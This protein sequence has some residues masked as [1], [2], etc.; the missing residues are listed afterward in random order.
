MKNLILKHVIRMSKL[1]TYAFL[2]QCLTMGLLLASN[3]NAQIKSI[4]EV[5]VRLPMEGVSVKDAFK[6]IEEASDFTFVYLT[7]EVRNLPPIFVEGRDQSLYEVLVEIA[8]QSGLDFKQINQNIH[9]Q[10]SRK[11]QEESIVS[12]SKV[13]VEIRGT[14]TE[15]NGD[16]IPGATILVEGSNT[17]TATDIDG[18]FSL[19]VDEGS[20]LLISFIG[21]KSQR[22]TVGNQ[23]SL[24]ITLMEDQSSLEEVVVVGYGAVRKRDLTG[25]I[26]SVDIEQQNEMPNVSV[27]QSL[28][29]RIP[30]L[31]VGAI[32]QSGQDPRIEVRGQNTLS[33]SAGDN[34]PLIVLDGII[35]RGNIIDINPA[36]IQS[37]EVLKDGSAAAIYGSQAAN[38]VIL[39]TSK[40]GVEM[41]K[42]IINYS[43]QYTIQ[44]PTKNIRPRN[45]AENKAFLPNVFWEQ[46]RLAPDYLQPNPDFIVTPFLKTQ[47][48]SE[49]YQTD[50]D[51]DWWGSFTGNGNIQTHDLSIRGRTANSGYFIAAGITDQKG[52]IKNDEYNRI[53]IT[54]NFDTQIT[55]WLN[56]GM[57]TFMTSSDYSGV[58]PGVGTVFH[59]QPFAPIFDS[60][61]NYELQPEAGLNPFLQTQIDDEDKR[62]NLFGNFHL[63]LKLPFLPGFN[64]RVNYGH[65]YRN[66][67]HNQF[68]PWGANFTGSGFKNTGN[69]YSYILDNI[70]SYE[71]S[72]AEDH[73]LSLTFLYGVE[74]I[75]T[76]FT[77]ASAQ[78]FSNP[79]LG[80]FR[81]QAGDPSL[82]AIT[83]GAEEESSLYNMGRILYGYKDRYLITATIRRD[84]F[85]GFGANNKFGI[86]PSI[87]A[88]WVVSEEAFFDKSLIEFLKIRASYG[89]TARRGVGRY[90]T[91]ARMNAAPSRVFGDGGSATIGQWITTMANPNLAWET[92]T[93]LNLGVDF[94]MMNSRLFGNIE[95][96]NNNTEDILYNIQIPQTTGFSNIA[97][98]IGE[99]FNQ[100]IEFSLTGEPIRTGDFSWQATLNFSRNRN[101]IRSILGADND[102][103]GIEDDIVTNQLFI[104]EPQNVVFDYEV[105][106]MWQ[107]ED[108]VPQGFFPGTYRLN[109]VDED[110]IIS[111]GDRKILG[112]RDPS[113]RLGFANTL[114]YKNLSLY[115][116]INSIQGGQD[117]YYADGSP[118]ASGALFKRDQLTYSNAMPFDYWMP[119]NPNAKYRRLDLPSSF[120]GRPY[121]QRSF[122]RLQ[123]ISLAYSFEPGILEK[124]KISSLKVN[125]SAKNL[126]TL[127]NWEGWDP[128]TGIGMVAGLPVMKAYTLGLNVQF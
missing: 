15:E 92:T 52:F 9:V 56:F 95:Y 50:R 57:E 4:E 126:V 66:N 110:G 11:G 78:N 32:T 101:E 68:N 122:V 114:R 100:G 39:L 124:W 7:R 98:N 1:F 55:D 96:Y 112:Y 107:L 62:L 86:F 75:Q 67:T 84:G 51:N 12:V 128:E 87:A 34:A 99:V 69:Y 115:V 19:D 91:Q 104:G 79:T 37:V 20:V 119:E 59:L 82:N 18:N 42:P 5:V 45:T 76:S 103:D 14:V 8:Q 47:Q 53:N 102:G 72:F 25:A 35:Y 106:G 97:T 123:D 61:G 6:K 83:S 116:F 105:I 23:S 127:T 71:K 117:F 26:A 85:S 88:G 111:P 3:G 113:Y 29:G 74:S 125:L 38:G 77:N 31:N 46:S 43:G 70:F 108:E 120:V 17:G 54:A 16:P 30:G 28:Q 10:T 2:F 81:M 48:I 118:Y 33:S 90:E 73:R 58:S 65:N 27:L 89:Q 64:Y 93:G 40:K 109:D 49:G 41:G 44:V 24:S 121:D 22:I 94:D 63:D 60:E 21:Y 36:Q 13:D 80:Y